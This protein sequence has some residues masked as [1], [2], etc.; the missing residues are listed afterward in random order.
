MTNITA[1]V[2]SE[3][4][5]VSRICYP[6]WQCHEPASVIKMAYTIDDEHAFLSENF[7]RLQRLFRKTVNKVM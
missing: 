2:A 5:S 4:S 6:W 7:P 3:F 1:I